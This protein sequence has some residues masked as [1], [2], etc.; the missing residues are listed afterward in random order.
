MDGNFPNTDFLSQQ[1]G[2]EWETCIKNLIEKIRQTPIVLTQ[3]GNPITPAESILPVPE[4]SNNVEPLWELLEDWREYC[5]ELPRR[6]EAIGWYNAIRS[7]GVYEHEAFDGRQLAKRIQ[8]CSGLN[9]L[10]S[11]LQEGVDA[12]KWLDRFYDFLKKDELFNDAIHDYS[13]VPNQVGKFDYLE[14]LHRDESIDQ[15]LKEI[16]GF[17]D[18]EPSI[19]ESLRHTLLNSLEDE[20]GAG[21]WDNK[22]VVD[23]LI[24]ELKCQII[25]NQW[26]NFRIASPHL[27][28]WIVRQGEYSLLQGFPV[29]AEEA[30]SDEPSIIRLLQDERPLAPVLSWPNDLQE[31]SDLFPQRHVLANTF[32]MP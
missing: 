11:M 2:P 16:G 20:V 12:V 6:N 3:S 5:E 1:M 17:F 15:E 19:K 4:K 13:F 30:N 32:L 26:D 24:D 8:D 9:V 14:E 22:S 25:Y 27:F 18:I 31:Y 29:F 10:R 21:A 28:A 23:T 7:W